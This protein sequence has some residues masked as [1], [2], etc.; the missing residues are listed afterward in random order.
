MLKEEI[1]QL[2]LKEVDFSDTIVTITDIDTS[3]DLKYTKVKISILPV[4]KTTFVLNVIKN[5]IYKIQKELNKKLYM[6][7]VP[8]MSFSVD[9]AEL[10]AQ[11]IEELLSQDKQKD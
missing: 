2:L 11:R 9:Q 7:S 5:N 8:K 4:E 10:K 1:S 6:R 3:S